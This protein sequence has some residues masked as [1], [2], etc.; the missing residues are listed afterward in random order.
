LRT[1][2]K[3]Y[4]VTDVKELHEWQMENLDNHPSFERVPK[5]EVCF[6]GSIHLNM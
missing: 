2:A 4:V 3:L 5:E 6:C 1:G